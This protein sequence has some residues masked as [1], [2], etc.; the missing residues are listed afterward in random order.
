MTTTRPRS[1]LDE[2]DRLESLRD[3]DQAG[4]RQFHRFIVR[5]EV[6]LHPMSRNRLDPTPINVQ[7]RDLSHGGMGFLSPEP[8]HRSSTWRACFLEHGYVIG[9]QA[10]MIRHCREVGTSLYL[11]GGQFIMETG[12]MIML[13]VSPGD[14]KAAH[15]EIE[16]ETRH[17]ADYL[18]PGDV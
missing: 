17:Q 15:A 18:P 12:L 8:L 13:G 9:E 1:L 16:D 2:L 7:L 5:G 4:Q 6:Q 10:L 14:L 3:P 11:V